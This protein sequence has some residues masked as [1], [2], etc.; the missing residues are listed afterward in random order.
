MNEE[1]KKYQDLARQ[2]LASKERVNYYETKGICEPY[3]DYAVVLAEL[4]DEQAGKMRQ[5]K[6]QYGDSFVDHLADFDTDEEE[7]VAHDW[8]LGDPVDIDLDTVHHQYRFTVCQVEGDSIRK[9][10]I[11]VELTDEQYIRLLAW[12]LYDDHLVINTLLCHDEALYK[13]IMREALC[14]FCDEEVVMLDH[15]F[16]LTMDEPLA[17]SDLIRK[18]HNIPKQSGYL[19]FSF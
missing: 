14:Y 12:H 8:F 4:T 17:D 18:E 11:L 10:E 2:F 19:F 3:A 15:P 13:H 6:E 16:T 5:L 1:F 7:D 9:R